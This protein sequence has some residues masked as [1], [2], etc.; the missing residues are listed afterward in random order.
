MNSYQANMLR[1]FIRLILVFV[2]ALLLIGGTR[3]I[4]R[5]TS[6]SI[7][8]RPLPLDSSNPERRT[9]GALTF[10][11]AWELSSNNEYFGGISALVALN[12]G[13]F[14]G[15]SDAGAMIGF[16]L[17]NDHDADRPFIAALPGTS[18]K[19][20]TFRDRDS[21]GLAYDPG[22]G[23]FWVSYEAHHAIRRFPPY[24][25]R[26]EGL[27]RLPD[28]E[29]W[30][31]NRGIEAM[32]RLPD[33]RFVLLAEDSRD[34]AYPAYL[35][36]GDPVAKETTRIEFRY[37]PP[38]GFKATDATPLPDGRL[39]VLNRRISFPN[40]FAAKL[41]ILDPA[42]IA[43]GKIVSGKTIATLAS[44]LLV[45]N[46]EGATT[47]QEKGQTIVWIISDNNFNIFQRTLLMKF[48]LNLSPHKKTGG[49][50]RPRL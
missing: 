5:N 38:L 50:N 2:L 8:L 10:L 29:N 3:F 18:G 4:Y 27:L 11:G 23:R 39:L 26:V 41:G 16:S 43:R 33:G 45:D 15:I 21:E 44:P 49:G 47:T 6:Q 46:M 22:S 12:D 32:A 28:T 19:G 42:S 14:I 20:I 48:A 24:L 7:T 36:S 35:Y 1:R 30:Y 37:R 17:K 9:V 31:R 40:G 13:R 34:G 25:D